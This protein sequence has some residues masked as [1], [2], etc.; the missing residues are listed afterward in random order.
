MWPDQRVIDFITKNF[1]PARVHVRDDAEGFKRFGDRYGSQ[2]TPTILV[3]DHEGNER[4]RLEGFMDADELLAQLGLGLGQIEF[5]GGDA[6]AAERRFRETAELYPKT[7]AAP[8][9]V[10]WAGASRYKASND[11]KALGDT[12][13]ALT[14]RYPESIWTKKASVW[15]A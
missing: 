8:E 10:Y 2:W 7:E 11:A 4:H 12:Y 9:A 14:S 1:I 6:S 15:K 5:K 3:L 13:R